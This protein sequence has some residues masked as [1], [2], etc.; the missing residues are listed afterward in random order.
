MI[1]GSVSYAEIY[2][3]FLSLMLFWIYVLGHKTMNDNQV[4]LSW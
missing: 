1:W 2:Y 4:L 3:I